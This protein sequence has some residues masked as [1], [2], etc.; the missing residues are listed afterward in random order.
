[1]VSSVVSQSGP[2]SAQAN[3]NGEGV[4]GVNGSGPGNNANFDDPSVALTPSLV[5]DDNPQE[6]AEWIESLDATIQTDGVERAGFLVNEVNRRALQ[7]A[8]KPAYPA[9]TPYINSIPP[10]A[11]PDYPGNR[12][13]ER[14]IKSLVRWNAM[15]MVVQA[16]LRDGTIGGH[17]S[18]FASSATLYEVAYN[19]FFRGADHPEGM[20]LVYFQGHASPGMYSRAYLEG[21]LND[22]QLANFRRELEKGGGL[23]SYP[24]PWLM[25]EFW[26]FPTVSMGLGPIMAIYQARF[27]K[28]LENRGLAKTAG[29]KVWAFL[30]DGECDE[31]ETLGALTIAAREKLDNL[32][33]V[34]NCNL[35]RLDGPVR[36]NG[37][38][39]QELE[40]LFRGA[41]WNPIK[42]IWGSN[43]DSLFARDR[44]GLLVRR[45]EEVVDGEYQKYAVEGGAYV[46]EHFFGK[47]PELL[48]LVE[49]MSDDEIN[50]LRRGG[51][52]P[53]KVYAA[54]KQATESKG[55][56][57]VVLAKTVKGYGLGEA[58]EGLNITHQQKK[59][60]SSHL[61]EFR[62]RFELT[63]GDDQNVAATPY[64]PDSSQPE[65]KYLA[66]RRKALGGPIPCRRPVSTPVTVPGPEFVGRYGKGSGDK[67][68]S[69][70]GVFVD[71]LGVLLKMQG[72]GKQI[73]PIVPDEGRTF[74][75]D[76]YFTSFKIYSPV[77]QLYDP[78][79]SRMAVAYRESSSGQ[80][81][82]E[83]INEAGSMASFIA[84][85][86]SYASN[87]IPM[88]PFYIYYSMFGFQR[89]GD[90]IWAAADTRVRGFMLG[91][92]SGRTSLN[93]E[94]LQHEDGHSHLMA[95]TVPSIQA[96][97]PAY[98][99]ELAAIL[100][101][102]IKRMYGG[103]NNED[104]LYY[105]SLYNDNYPMMPMPEG[106]EEGIL[107]GLYKLSAS[108]VKSD[109]PKIQI[110]GSG[111]ILVHSLAA[112]KILAEMGIEADV[113]SAT[114]YKRLRL[115]AL[116]AERYN[117][118]H[119]G[120]APKKSYLE[121]TLAKEQVDSIYLAVS[122]N[123]RQIPEMIGRWVPG[124]L[125]ALGTDGFGRSETRTSLRRH[126]EIDAEFIT[127]SA[128]SQLWRK[129]KIPAQTV[130]DYI[131]KT[132][133]DPEK[134]CP[135][136]A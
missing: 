43:W 5:R 77:G 53:V 111:P 8:I 109:L 132:G 30:G 86:S 55:G 78:V 87:G 103:P 6:T 33:F 92:T 25:P 16:N 93:G 12:D 26:Q 119:P 134:L 72:L 79:D 52:D 74:G 121:E 3:S 10:S 94:G 39:I 90:L 65:M 60:K 41:G 32:I 107:R 100:R 136:T 27:L 73:V 68:P 122:D 50:S 36:G 76:P 18:T 63:F 22:A 131:K 80:I 7:K 95:S 54:Y 20:D 21:R 91:A 11:Q 38:I 49:H 83:G 118:L 58:G 126:F 17:I 15:A 42:V 110:F 69:T 57:T 130:Q 48:K 34:I 70:T 47:Y 9:S 67:S 84:A 75:L 120:A 123:M 59:L 115:E 13:L 102:G 51:H 82:E 56:P 45:M 105:I 29:R 106:S 1:M 101:D 14:K 135:L 127:L 23:S 28:Y 35:Q 44:S 96:Y 37:K 113:W 71:M 104:I 24:H 108:S 81:L 40:S 98:A 19:H 62:K 112:Q 125:Y 85:G 88:I 66:E 124:G 117:L 133:I 114:S 128:L 116:E 89:V 4:S 46:R 64:R 2:K 61:V 31:P 99:F 129:G 97:D